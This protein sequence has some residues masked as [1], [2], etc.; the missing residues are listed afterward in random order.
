MSRGQINVNK[1]TN[2]LKD[3]FHKVVDLLYLKAKQKAP[4]QLKTAWLFRTQADE[5]VCPKCVKLEGALFDSDDK[6]YVPPI[7]K[8]CRCYKEILAINPW[9]IKKDAT[10][11][12]V[13]ID[14]PRAT[15]LEYGTEEQP[16]GSYIR[17]AMNEARYYIE[18]TFAKDLKKHIIDQ[19]KR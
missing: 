19:L 5:R 8:G 7:H 16:S 14:H 9:I 2:F 15:S 10:G 17:Q 11:G 1:F 3:Y 6:R 18:K 12:E 4:E 13:I